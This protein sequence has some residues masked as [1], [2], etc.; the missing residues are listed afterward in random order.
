MGPARPA[1]V[2]LRQARKGATVR[3]SAGVP[4]FAEPEPSRRGQPRC[5]QP[6]VTGSFFYVCTL[7]IE[8]RT[9]MPACGRHVCC[10]L[11]QCCP[12]SG[13]HWNGWTCGR[14]HCCSP[15][16]QNPHS[17]RARRTIA[18]DGRF[19]SGRCPAGGRGVNYCCRLRGAANGCAGDRCHRHSDH[20]RTPAHH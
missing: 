9:E 5:R 1:P 8:T 3:G 15:P 17:R 18:A 10:Q 2:E 6:P 7:P 14:C 16:A 19:D 20:P 13:T 11:Q 4:Q 12:A